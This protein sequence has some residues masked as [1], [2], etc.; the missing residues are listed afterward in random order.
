[1]PNPKRTGKAPSKP[2]TTATSRKQ[3]PSGNAN[4]NTD[5]KPSAQTAISRTIALIEALQASNDVDNL[6]LEVA[7]LR[8]LVLRDG[9]LTMTLR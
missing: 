3:K 6:K 9:T 7:K 5:T 8:R 2:S 1:M 4:A